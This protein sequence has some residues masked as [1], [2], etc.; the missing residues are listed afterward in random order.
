[1]ILNFYCIIYCLLEIF[2]IFLS[3]NSSLKKGICL[4]NLLSY[5]CMLKSINEYLLKSKGYY[6]FSST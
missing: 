3:C 2:S 6:N 1:M 4:L 5:F